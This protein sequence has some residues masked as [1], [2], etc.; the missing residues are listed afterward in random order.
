M[1]N[2]FI[3]S[4][5]EAL[6]PAQAIANLLAQSGV[7]SLVW[8]DAFPLSALTWE[9]IEHVARTVSG[10]VLLASPDDT[11][12]VRGRECR[13]PRA[14]VVLEW[15]FLTG[16]L[17]R[18]RVVLCKYEDVTLPSD[19][20]S[21]SYCSLGSFREFQSTALLEPSVAQRLSKWAERLSTVTGGPQVIPLH[22]YSGR[23]NVRIDY[24]L[25][26]G[27]EIVAEDF[28]YFEGMLDL[29]LPRDGQ[30]GSGWNAGAL[31]LS[32]RGCSAEFRLTDLI[33]SVQCHADGSMSLISESY[34]RQLNGVINGTPPQ[35]EGFDSRLP[36]PNRYE[37]KLYPDSGGRLAGQHDTLRAGNVR[38]SARV[39]AERA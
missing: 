24:S 26:R 36:G 10:A 2:V 16:L 15:G 28:A 12:T 20:D 7:N 3:G 33:S 25:W 6:K 5:M 18:E 38:S 13:L 37:M 1:I 19:L 9:A 11:A 17:G 22:G 39:L 14:N 27:I 30:G 34:T 23:W 31:Y 35:E 4:S 32:V 29:V 8:T 21:L